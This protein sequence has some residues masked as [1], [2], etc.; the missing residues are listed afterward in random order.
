MADL[1]SAFGGDLKGANGYDAVDTALMSAMD[2]AAKQGGD[3]ETT[4]DE[5]QEVVADWDG[6]TQDDGEK[7]DSSNGLG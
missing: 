6:N 4:L 1:D 2:S 5:G 3:K 7:E